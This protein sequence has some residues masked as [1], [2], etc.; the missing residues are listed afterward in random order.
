MDEEAEEKDPVNWQPWVCWVLIA[1]FAIWAIGRT[2]G[3]EN[4]FPAVQAMAYT[5]YVLL[6]SLVVLLVVVLLRKWLPF[7]VGLLAFI[8]LGFAVVPREIGSADQVAGGK[9]VN[10]MSLNLARGR[11]DLGEVMNLIKVR[12][13]DIL[14]LQEV[15]PEAATGLKDA[16][17]NRLLEHS[18]VATEEGHEGRFTG[19]AI[20]SRFPLDGLGQP[21]T[22]SRQPDA[23]VS[24]PEA[25]PFRLRSV[26]PMA[27]IGPRTTTQWADEYGKFPP[28]DGPGP[29]WVLAGD[30][31]ATLDHKR[32]RDVID[33]G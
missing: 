18:V 19:G 22:Y 14:T 5:P 30:F 26:H 21:A 29:P 3:L 28:A 6:L 15:T 27:P 1:P 2:F 9:E 20:F 24:A 31:N 12:Q 33:T 8:A 25:I 23:L 32:F 17:I 11:A 10:L 16:G 7:L 4:G 13:V